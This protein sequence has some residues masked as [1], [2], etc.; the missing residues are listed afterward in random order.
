MANRVLAET[1]PEV[2][3]TG[4]PG[5]DYENISTN[6]EMFGGLIAQ[7]AEKLGAGAEH[8]SQEAF[9]LS[10]F[11]Q[12]T[13]VNAATND[14]NKKQMDRYYFGADGKPG[15]F[16]LKG[17]D[18]AG[19]LP[20][21]QANIEA[22]REQFGQ[23]LSPYGKQQYELATRRS[24]L[25]MAEKA[26]AHASQQYDV[27][28]ANTYA[29]K[30][31]LA[32]QTVGMTWNDD[33]VFN[34]QA[35]IAKAAAEARVRLSTG[36]S[37][38]PDSVQAAI[39]E[40]HSKLVAARVEGWLNFDSKGATAFLDDQF[41]NKGVD[42]ETY[43]RLISRLR[44]INAAAAGDTAARTAPVVTRPATPSSGS[45]VFGDSLGV[46]VKS[47]YGFGGDAVKDRNPGQ[48]LAAINSA[49]DLTGKRV[50][51]S[52]GA[53]NSVG[54]VGVASDQIKALEAKGAKP[55][56]ITVLGVGDHSDFSGVNDRLQ[57]IANGAGV[58][59][60]AIDPKTLSSDRVHPANY[61][62]ILGD[63]FTLPLSTGGGAV[64]V[65]Q[66]YGAFHGQEFGAGANIQTSTD[67]AHGD[68]QIIP[69]TFA[70][71]AKPGE[72]LDNREDNIAVG[73][74]ILADYNS[75]WPSD[76]AR[77]AVAYF[78]GEKNVAPAGSD[79][80]WIR[81]SHDGQ[82]TFVH[83]YVND[84]L[85]R[86]SRPGL[87][88][89]SPSAEGRFRSP[90]PAAVGAWNQTPPLP[91][92]PTDTGLG[93][94]TTPTAPTSEELEEG[95]PDRGAMV[96]IAR[97]LAGGDLIQ[98]RMN[99]AEVNC[100][101]NELVS[102]TYAQRYQIEQELPNLM[103]AA[104]VGVPFASRENDIRQVF[105]KSKADSIIQNLKTAE[106]VGAIMK[107]SEFASPSELA[108]MQ[109]DLSN[110]LGILSDAIHPNRRAASTGPGTVGSGVIQD[111]PE[112]FRIRVAAAARLQ[113]DIQR[114]D[115]VLIGPEQDP[116]AYAAMHP[117][118]KAALAAI[119]PKNPATFENYASLSLGLQKYL[120]VPDALQHVLTR[121]QA[122]SLS[123]QIEHSPDPK[124][125]FQQLQQQFGAA[126]PHAF[127]DAVSLGRLPPA[128]QAV[129]ALDDP[130][131]AALLSRTL[132]SE[133]PSP[134]G[135]V[136]KSVADTVDTIGGKG[137]ADRIRNLAR[138]APETQRYAT[139]IYR[140]GAS[141]E[142]IAGIV[143]SVQTLALA[144]RA[145]G[146]SPD[147]AAAVAAS[148]ESFFGKFEYMPNGGARVPAAKFDA[149]SGNAQTM[150]SNL[151][152][153]SI[154]VP[155]NFGQTGQPDRDEYVN[156]LRASPTW[157]TSPRS[158]ALWLMDN[159]GRI[160]RTTGGKPL[161]VRFDAPAPQA[162][163]PAFDL[164]I[165]QGGPN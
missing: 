3:P 59:F 41:K 16:T 70:M 109:S 66:L 147:S 48:V 131:D 138:Y 1:Y 2:S 47:A 64:T 144:K 44:P 20:E 11:Y 74:R 129:Q 142:Q 26:G 81:D 32:Q 29:D 115:A 105:P 123:D 122:I 13:S 140:S 9:S 99:V 97:E 38:T 45:V 119:D 24:S 42:A 25:I 94:Q 107:G 157:V 57:R 116:A 34:Q 101:Y 132:A 67:N 121:G 27:G 19:S 104:Q 135:K 14:F 156:V 159:E 60:Q 113:Q 127:S 134:D 88:A 40:A 80:P 125:T 143:N 46:G 83:Q 141:D 5:N 155:T 8:A 154:A 96:R 78:S 39:D 110:N 114:R 126:W 56:D 162:A 55:S 77:V 137:E 92:I 103:A 117:A 91:A 118:V 71:Y 102:M 108:K 37:A 6:P 7:G 85:Q 73:K 130:H 22:D 4:A 164:S 33:N 139:S 151:T 51:L 30:E 153:G 111:T 161:E 87:A 15:F 17:Y 90:T 158:D 76:P 165:E 65:E 112:E 18:A 62:G 98:A 146:D 93:T 84:I 82:G 28:A 75:R 89:P 53:S 36:S 163:S 69:S 150:L 149:V 21:L 52:T 128:Y 86:L 120:G 136:A 35:D 12:D 124:S 133:K 152:P 49:G 58:K 145:A 68:M 54:D 43:D 63:K 61:Q 31:K 23:G 72:R 79:T 95:L 50:V 160:V 100:R 148:L 10:Q 106:Q